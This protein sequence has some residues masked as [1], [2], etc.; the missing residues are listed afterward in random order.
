MD[1]ADHEVFYRSKAEKVSTDQRQPED[2]TAGVISR[3]ECMCAGFRGGVGLPSP[4]PTSESDVQNFDSALPT[5]GGM[6]SIGVTDVQAGFIRG[7]KV[8]ICARHP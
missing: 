6:L 8:T 5:C 4:P 7:M 1:P 2:P 3:Y